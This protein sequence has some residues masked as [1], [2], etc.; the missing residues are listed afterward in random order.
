MPLAKTY[1][2]IRHGGGGS[3]LGLCG[4]STSLFA[5]LA[6]AAFLGMIANLHSW[7]LA[8]AAQLVT[9]APRVLHE[10][11]RFSG[12]SRSLRLLHDSMITIA[13]ASNRSTG[14]RQRAGTLCL[15]SAI[16]ALRLC[17]AL[18]IASQRRTRRGAHSV[19][20]LAQPAIVQSVLSNHTSV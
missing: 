17:L 20:D 3:G 16:F 11:R 12:F 6:H 2:F 10:T 9:R 19:C 5:Q 7:Q 15:Q 18:V 4:P 14:S 13:P 1:T 8:N